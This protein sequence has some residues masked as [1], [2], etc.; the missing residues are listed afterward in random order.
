MNKEKIKTVVIS[1]VIGLFLGA[2]LTTIFGYT[3]ISTIKK[4]LVTA[5]TTITS[6][7]T[8]MTKL[9]SQNAFLNRTFTQSGKMDFYENGKIKSITWLNTGGENSGSSSS[10][11]THGTTNGTSSHTG[12]SVA[13]EDKKD[14]INPKV[15][16]FHLD[17]GINV[18][19][20][21]FLLGGSADYKPS[22][23]MIGVQYIYEFKAANN[24]ILAHIGTGL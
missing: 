10:S 14:I 7:K 13:T 17:P 16:F 12:T 19:T 11:A 3:K 23:Y 15:F 21:N 18:N 22:W 24:F 8:E 20:K 9:I 4:T 1:L 6:M 2:I 5:E